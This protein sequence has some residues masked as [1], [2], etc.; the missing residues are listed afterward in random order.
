MFPSRADL[1]NSKQLGEI[2]DLMEDR[3]WRTLFELRELLDNRYIETS[4]SA[5]LRDL[6]KNKYGGHTVLRRLRKRTR[7][8][9]EYKVIPRIPGMSIVINIRGCNGSGK[10]TAVARLMKKLGVA[11]TLKDKKGKVWAYKLKSKPPTYVLGRYE[12]ACGGCDTM[13]TLDQVC[14][15]VWHLQRFGNV[16]FEGVIIS[17]VGQRWVD[18]AHDC[19]AQFIFAILDTPLKKC[20][21]RVYK[22]REEKG[23]AGT[24][25]ESLVKDKYKVVHKNSRRILEKGGMDVR[26]LPHKKPVGTLLKW[27]HLS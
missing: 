14:A 13:K 23:T 26:L 12:T 18:L 17:T 8:T 9:Y 21:H 20:I 22:R 1:D 3:K 11:K 4:I 15:R 25:K 7:R 27:L 2:W 10:S 6:R 19:Q 16:I 5:R 24:F